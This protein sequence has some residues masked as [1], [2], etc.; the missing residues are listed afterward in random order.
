MNYIEELLLRQA[1]AF[2]ALLSG[3][4]TD[5][6]TREDGG[7]QLPAETG[8]MAKWN[9]RLEA[10]SARRRAETM[11]TRARREDSAGGLDG[12]E[13]GF[14]GEEAA[15]DAAIERGSGWRRGAEG[16]TTITAAREAEKPAHSAARSGGAG[17][18]ETEPTRARGTA[19]SAGDFF[20]RTN[21]DLRR[22]RAA[23]NETVTRGGGGSDGTAAGEA[24][25][26]DAETAG[27]PAGGGP[28]SGAEEEAAR[29]A[30]PG[31]SGGTDAGTLS[32][33]FQ[34]DARRYDGGYPL[35]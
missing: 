21:A 9:R 7:A 4:E 17:G 11:L 5:T 28:W 31:S 10:R 2:A 6:D 14:D 27:R 20:S 35:Y 34:R 33:A 13:E 22:E 3:G 19:R 15:F 26:R 24:G 25:W 29:Q 16:W 12:T 30:W 1:A 23:F 18:T 32:R 8:R